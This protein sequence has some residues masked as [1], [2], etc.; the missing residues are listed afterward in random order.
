LRKR[1]CA[2][3]EGRAAGFNN[4]RYYHQFC[5]RH[6][7]RGDC[8]LEDADEN[9]EALEGEDRVPP[10]PRDEDKSKAASVYVYAKE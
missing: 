2:C 9:Y 3:G 10:P 8:G 4:T 6:A 7:T 1:F 5:D